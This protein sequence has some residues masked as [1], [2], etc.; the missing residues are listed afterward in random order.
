METFR[1]KDLGF[2]RVEIHNI[3]NNVAGLVNLNSE[4]KV[5]N[6]E[7]HESF[8]RKL[9]SGSSHIFCI[10]KKSKRLDIYIP[11]S[12]FANSRLITRIQISND[13]DVK[14]KDIMWGATRAISYNKYFLVTFNRKPGPAYFV[15]SDTEREEFRQKLRRRLA[16]LISRTT[17]TDSAKAIAAK[18]LESG[19][20]N[21]VVNICRWLESLTNV[22]YL[23]TYLFDTK[24]S[25]S[26]NQIGNNELLAMLKQHPGLPASNTYMREMTFKGFKL[27]KE[28]YKTTLYGQMFNKLSK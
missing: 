24:Y 20:Y 5:Q 2:S 11:R 21:D 1:L 12:R 4:L 8:R 19:N 15:A 17:L 23:D 6:L 26:K 14:Q 10:G 25:F 7:N 16:C 18:R 13:T 9:A 22:E 28:A 3:Y 27:F